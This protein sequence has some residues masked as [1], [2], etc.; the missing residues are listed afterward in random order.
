MRT[1]SISTKSLVKCCFHQQLE[2]SFSN[3]P[4]S[5]NIG[6]SQQNS[7][8]ILTHFALNISMFPQ[9]Y[10]VFILRNIYLLSLA[11]FLVTALNMLVKYNT[12]KYCNAVNNF[13]KTV[14]V[15]G[16]NS[17][18]HCKKNLKVTSSFT[19]KAISSC[20]ILPEQYIC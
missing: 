5:T 6:V 12:S 3:A 14:A 8:E 20:D 10:F 17:A 16:H 4:N 13:W 1:I 15:T 19:G 18:I 7:Y 2:N 11:L 9:T